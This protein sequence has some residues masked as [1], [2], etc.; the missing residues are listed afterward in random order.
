[1]SGPAIRIL[2][3][4]VGAAKSA[5]ATAAMAAAQ[6]IERRGGPAVLIDITTGKARS[7][8][9]VSPR[10][11]KAIESSL[12]A[13]DRDARVKARGRI[14]IASV[15]DDDRVVERVEALLE[16]IPSDVPCVIL[17]P[18]AR[19]R[20]LLE[21][22]AVGV[23]EVI[24]RA[25][26]SEDDGD[27]ALLELAREEAEAVVPS[28]RVV[29]DRPGWR[30][31]RRALAGARIS[32]ESGQA[33]PLVLGAI[34]VLVLGTIALV[35]IAG[36]ITGKAR[37][38]TTA[39]LSALSAVRSMKT[40]L[41]R[42]LAP[43]TLPNGLPNPAH[44]SKFQYLARAR[45][46]AVTIAVKNGA[47]PLR[48]SVRFPD[49]LSF[50]P[51][52]AR[53]S[54]RSK[55]TGVGAGKTTTDWAEARV[56]APVAMGVVP[57]MATGG[58]YSGPL[59]ERQGNGMR[60]DVAEAF[61]RMAAAASAAGVTLTINS[62]FRS[63]AEQAAL[64]AA[65][66]NPTMVARP[67]TSLHRCGT[68]LDLGASDG[69]AWLASNAT[70][71][72][73]V[74]RYSWEAW[75]YGFTAGPEP[76]SA[77]GNH[78]TPGGGDPE[79]GLAG[80]LPSWVPKQFR[81]AIL[82]SAMKWNVSAPLLAAQLYAE[83][84]FDPNAGNGIAF[85]IAAFTPAAAAQYGLK[86]PFDPDQAIEAQGHLMSDL[87]KQF[88][89]PALALAAYNAGP[90]AVSPCNCVPDYPETQAYVTKILGMLGGIGAIAPMPMEVE[91][92]K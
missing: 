38:Q 75:H 71:F 17:S 77:E 91:L 78:V 40:D 30:L 80:S 14:C 15:T 1:M 63:D 47:S 21:R 81:A 23:S 84:G 85:G 16:S 11:T 67:G 27:R 12:K 5:D 50:A 61:D 43:P 41:P 34:F 58:G 74:Q 13:V 55:V 6:A 49:S 31:A 82:R 28:V 89:S 46:A 66:P 60:P 70:R 2:V 79:G 42:L 83:S 20:E 87:L 76:C 45:V 26:E 62:A 86:D 29:A 7:A 19:Y 59:A 54:V 68:E 37:A 22:E 24:L 9:L 92:V 44:M 56:G 18:P 48:V 52:R 72:G 33:T 88:G 69:Y 36:A 8:T 64:F 65:N 90:G 25:D 10:D 4:A 51:V 3:T 73:F 39:D 53:V 57:S 32:G 35:A